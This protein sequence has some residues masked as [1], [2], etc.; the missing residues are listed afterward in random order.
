MNASAI[1]GRV[2]LGF[3]CG[4]P[5]SGGELYG[6]SMF[7]P[8]AAN[9]TLQGKAIH[10]INEKWGVHINS[11]YD[12]KHNHSM[13]TKRNIRCSKNGGSTGA[14]TIGIPVCKKKYAPFDF[15]KK[16]VDDDGKVIIQVV[17]M[18]GCV[19]HSAFRERVIRQYGERKGWEP[20][21]QWSMKKAQL[22]AKKLTERINA[23]N[24]L[25]DSG[26]DATTSSASSY[27][28]IDDNPIAWKK[29]CNNGKCAWKMKH[30][31]DDVVEEI[32]ERIRNE[33]Y[34]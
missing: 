4:Y 22:V 23:N 15:R 8:S 3:V 32:H 5:L 19:C 16:I 27:D 11:R 14:E 2:P 7:I 1:P 24:G 25:I 21:G 20:F 34:R 17:R 9:D 31:Y 33:E 29:M 28:D 12:H 6:G 18:Y 10:K 30:K 26:D 13:G